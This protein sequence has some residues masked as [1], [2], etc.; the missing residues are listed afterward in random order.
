IIPPA[1]KPPKV[2]K[3]KKVAAAVTVLGVVAGPALISV[4]HAHPAAAVAAVAITAGAS[5][6]KLMRQHSA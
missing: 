6:V 2:A 3:V 4:A 5:A 1:N